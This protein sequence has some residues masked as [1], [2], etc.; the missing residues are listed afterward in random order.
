MDCMNSFQ[1]DGAA[2]ATV[3]SADGSY[4]MPG[5]QLDLSNMIPS[6]LIG[7]MFNVE[8]VDEFGQV[9]WVAL[10]KNSITNTAIN[11]I[12]AQRY[13]A[14][15]A[16]S[17]WYLLL[18]DNAGFSAFSLAD[19]MTSHA[20]WSEVSSANVSDTT[21]VQWVPGSPS[22]G[23][24][25][26]P[27]SSDYH[28]IPSSPITVYGVGLVSNNTLGGTSGLLEATAAFLSGPQS[29]K[30]GDVL[31]ITYITGAATN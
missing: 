26:N 6:F 15:T 29:C 20:G 27:S 22:S 17:T 30:N 1:M 21:R 19:T 16:Y 18:V 3:E 2:D 12:L 7:G 25:T 9:Q 14:G 10:A 24:I 13:A 4:S 5:I 23:S 11:S 8:C 31:R 28:M